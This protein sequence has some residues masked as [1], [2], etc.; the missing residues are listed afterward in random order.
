MSV[1]PREKEIIVI[2]DV[3][4]C[5]IGV[6]A[7]TDYYVFRE[8]CNDLSTFINEKINDYGVYIVS[9]E[10]YNKC[11]NLFKQLSE[12]G[13]LVIVIDPPKILRKIEPKKYYEEMITRFIGMKIE[14]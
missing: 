6:A 13:Y 5:I 2:G 12:K 7:G 4:L 10:V 1:M 3:N 8:D 14:L 9:R 11:N